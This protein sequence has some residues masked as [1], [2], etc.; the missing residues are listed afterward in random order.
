MNR[1]VWIVTIVCAT[2]Y[3]AAQAGAVLQVNAADLDGAARGRVVYS[4]WDEST[5]AYAPLHTRNI[6]RGVD[7]IGLAP[8]R[9]QVRVVYT[10][11]IPE[12]EATQSDI[13]LSDS[14]E[15]VCTFRF[16]KAMVRVNAR[17]ND[18]CWRADTRVFLYRQD[19]ETGEY[20]LLQGRPLSHRRTRQWFAVAPGA[21]K[22]RV[23]YIETRPET[24][25]AEKTFEVADGDEL[26]ILA[27][28]RHGPMPVRRKHTPLRRTGASG[29]YLPN[30]ALTERTDN[31]E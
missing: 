19:K 14:E 24:E 10:E 4:R 13:V 26:P 11:T 15:R 9:Y 30:E 22:V 17:D 3:G 12:Q 2:V 23:E 20:V 29:R 16:E 6:K 31:T 27:L 7:R 25:F 28:F 21:Y 18:W 8:G 1:L 5:Q